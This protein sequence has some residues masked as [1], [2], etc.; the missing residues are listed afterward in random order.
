MTELQDIVAYF[1]MNRFTLKFLQR[2]KDWKQ[3]ISRPEL[4]YIE[5]KR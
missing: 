5:T 3:N 2:I 4:P 1:D